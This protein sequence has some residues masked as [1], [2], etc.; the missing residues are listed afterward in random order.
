MKF[1]LS[2]QATPALPTLVYVGS[3]GGSENLKK[4]LDKR[5][6]DALVRLAANKKNLTPPGHIWKLLIVDQPLLVCAL[7]DRPQLSSVEF[8]RLMNGL[9]EQLKHF[10]ASKLQVVVD[11]LS[12]A[13]ADDLQLLRRLGLALAAAFYS[14]DLYKSTRQKKPRVS[15][16]I[17]VTN[18]KMEQAADLCGNMQAVVGGMNLAKDLANMPGN[19]CTP[20]YLAQQARKMA[21]QSRRLRCRVLGERRLRSL[22]MNAYL[23]VARGSKQ[24]PQFI[25]LEYGGGLQ[26]SPPIVLLGKGMTFDSGGI[27]LKSAAQMDE[28][29]YDMCGAASVFGAMQAIV[30]LAPAVNVV[31]AI[32]AAENMPD[33][34]AYRPGD[35]ITTLSG[36][37]VEV[38]NT[39][40]EGRMVLCDALTYIKRYKPR[41]VV[42]MATLTGACVIALGHL[43]SGFFANDEELA[44]AVEAAAAAYND[45]IWRLPMDMEYKESMKSNFA[46]IAHIGGRA[47]GTITAACFL[48]EFATEYAW[49]H[50][51]IAGTAWQGGITKGATGRPVPLLTQFVLNSIK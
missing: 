31:G 36:K 23:A 51:D 18:R 22:G 20:S 21:T 12:L 39:D 40:A 25:L 38:L 33:A 34:N 15:H 45:G 4:Q 9:A 30:E 7:G 17:F 27:S 5:Y 1:T 19:E 46:D 47:A 35:I 14:F 41:Y 29:K 2:T 11:E 24:P 48:N 42:D 26:R 6:Y 49:G 44:A 28:M 32:A 10:S 43:R 50:L 3:R 37:T 13:G 8:L 16:L